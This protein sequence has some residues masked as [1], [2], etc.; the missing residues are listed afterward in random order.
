MDGLRQTCLGACNEVNQSLACT[1]LST[2]SLWQYCIEGLWVSGTWE[3]VFVLVTCM[4]V[5]KVLPVHY[6]TY[7]PTRAVYA[8]YC[9]DNIGHIGCCHKISKCCWSWWKWLE[10]SCLCFLFMS[11][12]RSS[13]ATCT[14]YLHPCSSKSV[15]QSELDRLDGIGCDHSSMLW[16]YSQPTRYCSL[17]LWAWLLSQ[18]PWPVRK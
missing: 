12:A 15:N 17:Y 18:P 10:D 3:C 16:G 2:G 9:T 14:K 8:R 11:P 1:V 7:H 6:A 5:S 13:I 4:G